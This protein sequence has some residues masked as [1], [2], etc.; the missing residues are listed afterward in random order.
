MVTMY[1]HQVPQE[2]V[3]ACVFLFMFLPPLLYIALVGGKKPKK[4][5][6]RHS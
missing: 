3:V 4:K 2:V 5:K 1:G 6:G